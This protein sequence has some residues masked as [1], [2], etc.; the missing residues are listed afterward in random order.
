LQLDT[1]NL[2]ALLVGAAVGIQWLA[3]RLR[4]PALLLLLTFGI[5][6]GPV[7]GLFNPE[8]V[9]ARELL[10]PLV[11]LAVALV[12]FEGGL[13]LN[14]REAKYAGKT[15]WRL[16]VSGL[17][18]GFGLVTFLAW[19]V[20]GLEVATAATLG[21]I[22]VVTGPTV[23]IP[24]L[25]SARI[26]LRPATLLKWEGIVNDPFGAMLAFFVFEL[27]LLSKEGTGAS[28][29]FT[30]LSLEFLLMAVFGAALG[31]LVAYSLGRALE[32][33]TIPEHL[34][35]PVMLGAALVV[36]SM[37]NELREENGLL[38]VTTMGLF[39][40]NIQSQSLEDIRRFKEQVSTLLVSLLFIVLSAQLELRSLDKLI[41]MPLLLV[42]LIVFVV[43]PVI[44]FFA[45]LRTGLPWAERVLLGWIAPRGVVAAAVAG[46]FA[47]KLLAKGYPSADLLVPIVF[48][49]IITTVL[50]HGLSIRPL[51]RRL[52]LA[53]EGG[54]GVLMI[55][56]SQWGVALAL[57]L[58]KAGAFVVL[59]DTRYR[60]VSRARIEGLEV[61]Y[62]D[63]LSEETAL[64]LPLE[65]ISF[66]FA[67]TDDDAYNSLVCLDFAPDLGR[68][69]VFQVSITNP[70]KEG[71]SHLRGR[72][73]W[74]E[75]GSYP[76]VTGRFWKGSGFK[77]TQITENFGWEEL[78][79][80]NEDSLFLF[81]VQQG[82][83]QA[84]TEEAK[85]SAG[86]KVV[87]LT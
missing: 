16:I 17:V 62:G 43:R 22:L 52:G 8:K 12:L 71:K 61:H 11:S 36:F 7:T 35:S 3:A 58:V 59:A 23:I 50:L 78:V 21:A 15:L 2:L 57:A 39:L 73:P 79:S 10:R 40:A 77:V 66:V 18:L 14:L 31:V 29:G 13:S 75:K 6:V 82:K 74:G 46:A 4:F 47:P 81:S 54:N 70:P 53:A 37:G 48:G 24:M 9:V 87:Y 83:L 41:G 42:A 28:H 20:A 33:G 64:E 65:R 69:C 86:A 85:P 32:A 67:G 25:R 26:S 38:A 27:A 68:E 1:I 51:A 55:G 34:K 63:V 19:S 5:I 84:I 80:K 44:V 45:T 60:R 56:A 30:A 76:A 49:V 72:M